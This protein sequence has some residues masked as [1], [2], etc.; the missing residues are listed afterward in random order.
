MSPQ[1]TKA[2]VLKISPF[3]ETSCILYLLTGDH[4]LVHAVAKGVKR[5][6]ACVPSL[7]R[8]FLVEAVLYYRPQR[9][10]HTLGGITV[11]DY[12]SS[13]RT[14]LFKNTVRDIVFEVLLKTMSCDSPHPEIFSY[15]ADLLGRMQAASAARCF[16]AMVWEFLYHF[17]RLMGVA[18]AL[19]ACSSCG[20]ALSGEHGAFL[21]MESGGMICAGC[22]RAAG[23]HSGLF[24]PPRALSSLQNG[25]AA[26]D[27]ASRMPAAEVRRITHLLARYCR[28]HFHC[29][30][31][32]KSV[33]FLN[34][35]LPE[36]GTNAGAAEGAYEHETINY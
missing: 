34:S 26:D 11:L 3:R 15:C 25:A 23:T 10:L 28:Y 35:I 6:R 27:A 24:L 22:A 9:D 4:G 2:F 13:I 19:D 1:T 29:T 30:S 33:A 36:A 21:L 32:F 17:S 5:K 31:D 14:D 20:G 8:G 7:E 18:P 16:P 12:Y